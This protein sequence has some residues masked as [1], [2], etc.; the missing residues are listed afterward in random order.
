VAEYLKVFYHV[1]F[2]FYPPVPMNRNGSKMEA[3][4]CGE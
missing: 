3:W 4:Q 1:G 2:F